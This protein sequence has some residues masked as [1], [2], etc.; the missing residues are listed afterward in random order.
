[1]MSEHLIEIE[2][3]PLKVPRIYPFRIAWMPDIHVGAQMGLF[4]ERWV[5]HY[6]TVLTPNPGQV[7]LR[8]YMYD[9]A[10]ECDENKCN[11]LAMPGDLIAGQN[12]RERGKYLMNIELSE[13]KRACAAVIAEF[14]DLVPTIEDIWIWK[15]TGYHGSLD[16][17]VEED[18]ANML[19][20]EYGLNARYFGEYSYINLKYKDREKHLWV[21]HSASAAYMYPEQAMGR[22]ML[23]FQEAQAQGKIPHIDMIIRAHK[24]SFI[25]VHK[26][27]IRSLQLPCFQFF[28][29]YDGA[30]KNYPIYQPDIGGV[31]MLFDEKLRTTVWH[32]TYPNIIE[33]QRFINIELSHGVNEKRLSR[34]SNK[35]R[36]G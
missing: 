32:F 13:Q 22:D 26:P 8:K 7:I 14:C 19:R 12:Y 35:K 2:G 5:D 31:I 3:R 27:S 33:P 11:I 1:M 17:S 16:T 15:G 10:R 34:K 6:G 21:A 28:V 30:V 25:E 29:P 24:H 23:K 9:F 36:N 18:I 4:P 20:A